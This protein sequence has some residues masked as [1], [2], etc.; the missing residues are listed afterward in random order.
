M[1][2]NKQIIIYESILIKRSN[3]YFGTRWKSDRNDG[4]YDIKT[5]FV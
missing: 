3:Y 5:N 2:G 4:M 1:R